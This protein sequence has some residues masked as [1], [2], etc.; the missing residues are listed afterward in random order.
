MANNL[1]IVESPAKA[2]TIIRYLGND[3]I[4]DASMGH[5]R[6]LP[7]G[8]LG[9]EVGNGVFEPTY[10][11][12]PDKRKIVSSLSKA[13]KTA[14]KVYLATDPDREGEAI[15]WHLLH[16]AKIDPSKVS[17]VVFHE[18]TKDAIV[19][20]FEH[21]RELDSNLI[22]AQQARRVLDRLVGYKLSPLLWSKIRR[23]LSAGR[24]QSV[25]LRLVV[26]RETEINAFIPREYWTVEAVFKKDTDSFNA[27]L[28]SE[29]GKKGE[30]NIPD[31]NLAKTIVSNIKDAEFH[32]K[33]VVT[34]ESKSRPSPP[35][36]TSTL[37]Q[38]ASRKL[39]FTARRT[40][41]VAQQLYEGLE[42]G[43]QGSV[44]L[45]TYMRT[46]S[47]NVSPAALS[48]AASYIKD[49]FGPE[50]T[51][52]SPRLYKR[53][54]KGA[55]EAHE[56]IRPTSI[57]KAQDPSSVEKYLT[58]EQY[59][60]YDLIWKRMLASQM[61]DALFDST[62]VEVC[63]ETK[64]GTDYVFRAN[65][66]VLKFKGFR[67]L[68]I[69]TSDDE[70][71]GTEEGSN[72][73]PELKSGDDV[74]VD[75]IVPE[76]HFTQPPARYS[77][78]SLIKSLE[79]NGI[80]RPSTYATI[81]A[82]II[83]RDYARKDKNRLVPT[84]LGIAVTGF[85]S[86]YFSDIMEIGFTA[87]VEEQLDDI[88]NG[89]MAWKPM[90]MDFYDPFEAVLD[91][92]TETAERVPSDQI[93]EPS[94]EICEK[95][96]RHMVIKSGRFGRFLSC[97]G[98]PECKNSKPLINKIGVNCPE[99]DSDLLERRRRGKSGKI[100]YGCSGYPE[101]D[102]LTNNK[103]LPQPCPDCGKMLTASGRSNAECIECSF[104]GPVPEENTVAE[105][106]G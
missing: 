30:I 4:A 59:R 78:A 80:G 95:C 21:P 102:F 60:L 89:E 61:P 28:H 62:T 69:E 104:K 71:A 67:V 86:N 91:E 29:V 5:V 73:L 66:S 105:V 74:K 92:A 56:A 44:G 6:D 31:G 65:G 20:A 48:E 37:Q 90:L 1:V 16:A 23:G 46:D 64:T 63:T 27:K 79:E 13:A 43:D 103:P 7:K 83:D 51:P 72:L 11:I 40:M 35:F 25:A 70:E 18:I 41:Q 49:N 96:E 26:D 38:E 15:A 2:R 10:K 3:F 75:T 52:K 8:E 99:C 45:I 14:S 12:L 97:S 76:Q 82:T 54:V 87:K 36:I 19:E 47:T 94:D 42:L 32:V 22:D 17:R 77:E 93:D 55:Q 98:F 88:A 57:T 68:Y 39:R 58:S 85:L 84:R 53:K 24:V 106:A 50:Y 100:F 9:V 33:S 101:C 34:K 81:I